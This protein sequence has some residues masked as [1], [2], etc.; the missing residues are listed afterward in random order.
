MEH[1]QESAGAQTSP[2][3]YQIGSLTYTRLQLIKLFVVLLLGGFSL[4]FIGMVQN[5]G[6][7]T[8]SLN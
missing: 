1:N 6:L 8:L 7:F 5:G 2:K 3:L 4:M